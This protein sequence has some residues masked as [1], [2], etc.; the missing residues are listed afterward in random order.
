MTH[1]FESIWLLRIIS[2]MYEM[3]IPEEGLILKLPRN[4]SMLSQKT[5]KRELI[6]LKSM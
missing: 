3:M 1:L 6:S 4:E 2:E 5:S